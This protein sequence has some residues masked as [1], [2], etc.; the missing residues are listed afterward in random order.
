MKI[1]LAL[2]IGA[3]AIVGTSVVMMIVRAPDTSVRESAARDRG[4]TTHAVAAGAPAVVVVDA[5]DVVRLRDR[6]VLEAATDPSSAVGVRVIDPALRSALR[7][8]SDDVITSMSGKP[9]R[10]ISDVVA[11]MTAG[12]MTDVS[13]LYIELVRGGHTVL[14]EWELA[15]QL[16]DALD[17]ISRRPLAFTSPTDPFLLTITQHSDSDFTLPRST[18]ERIASD[19][20]AASGTGRSAGVRPLDFPK[21]GVRLYAVQPGTVWST[22]GFKSGDTLKRAN[23]TE[24][25]LDTM[26]DTF[27]QLRNAGNIELELLRNGAPMTLRYGVK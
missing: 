24:L 19:V 20:L 7:M 3:V 16:G 27:D 15:G 2:A 8:E 1:A 12:I 22:L 25:S 10:A 4:S 6:S 5:R 13:S 9:V 14:L 18:L 17:P 11:V 26:R 21:G 23:G